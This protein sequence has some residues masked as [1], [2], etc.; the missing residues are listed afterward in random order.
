M[1]LYGMGSNKGFRN[2]KEYHP[3]N[4]LYGEAPNRI[5]C[6]CPP[7]SFLA[8]SYCIYRYAH[9]WFLCTRIFRQTFSML[10]LQHHQEIHPL[11]HHPLCVLDRVLTPI[12]VKA[13]H[14]TAV[15]WDVKPS[16]DLPSTP[17][18]GLYSLHRSCQDIELVAKLLDNPP[19]SAILMVWKK[20]LHSMMIAVNLIQA[21][22][23]SLVLV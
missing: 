8:M 18:I 13:P 20:C 12:A 14:G 9:A 19:R 6:P 5:C 10:V 2:W 3:Q 1:S 21:G 15:K 4:Y 16:L 23:N 11:L 7:Y 22:V 17:A